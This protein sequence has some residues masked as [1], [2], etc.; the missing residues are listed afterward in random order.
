MSIQK[1][2]ALSLHDHPLH[3][4]SIEFEAAKLIVIVE[5]YNEETGVYDE[6][7][8]CFH[9]I[10]NLNMGFIKTQLKGGCDVEV[11][12]AFVTTI[13]EI[14][15]VDFIILTGFGEPSANVTFDF[16]EVEIY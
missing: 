1:L 13:G 2:E 15:T 3:S 9:G 4:L 16:E 14:H 10:D 12:S 6:V 5:Q 11:T 7:K 8:L